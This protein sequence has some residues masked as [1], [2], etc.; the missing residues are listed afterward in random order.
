MP[1]HRSNLF[2]H[3]MTIQWHSFLVVVSCFWC[4]FSFSSSCHINAEL[5]KKTQTNNH[6]IYCL[7]GRMVWG[8]NPCGSKILCTHPISCLSHAFC[9]FSLLDVIILVL[10][11]V[12]KLQNSYV[13]SSPVHQPT[14]LPAPVPSHSEVRIILLQWRI[15]ILIKQ[16]KPKDT[17]CYHVL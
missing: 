6:I 10:G 5:I 1:P 14:H 7:M 12:H 8:S 3:D 17:C 4:C 13:I 2:V 11:K 15:I 16:L 9:S